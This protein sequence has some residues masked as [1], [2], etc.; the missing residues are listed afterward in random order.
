MNRRKFFGFL[1]VAPVAVPAA[2]MAAESAYASGY[3]YGVEPE[4]YHSP[5]MRM[6]ITRLDGERVQ[7]TYPEL[8]VG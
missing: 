6:Y 3:V 8:D 5:V 1:A 7:L 2:V 4:V